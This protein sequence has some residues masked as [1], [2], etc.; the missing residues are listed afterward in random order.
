MM[1]TVARTDLNVCEPPCNQTADFLDLSGGKFCPVIRLPALVMNALTPAPFH[2]HIVVVI[3][4]CSNEQMIG[5]EASG[6]VATVENTVARA[7]THAAE[8][9]ARQTMHAP[10][11]ASD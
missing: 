1:D 4:Y 10:T 6:V 7:K 5:I 11:V 9:D 2:H 3:S 8:Y